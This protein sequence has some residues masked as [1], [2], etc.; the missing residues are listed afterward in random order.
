MIIAVK[1]GDKVVVGVTICD[2]SIDMSE[3]DLALESNLPFW[4][5]K[6]QNDCYVCTEDLTY[7]TDLFRYNDYI[8]KD[9]SDGKSI[10][11]NVLPKMKEILKRNNQLINGK[12]WDNQMLIIKGGKVFRITNY[13][14]LAEID[15]YTVLGYESNV[16]CVLDE[17]KD[18]TP[19]DS[20]LSSIRHLNRM[21]NKQLFPVTIFDLQG[22]KKQVYYK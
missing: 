22:R 17:T 20:I 18:D 14:N 7:S 21:R 5:V 16:Q 12:E 13:L 6:G 11:E 3:K 19:I 4:R 9:I 15:D 1:K 2:G 10:I 8:F